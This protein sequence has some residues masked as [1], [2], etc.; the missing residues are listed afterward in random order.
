MTQDAGVVTETSVLPTADKGDYRPLVGSA[1]D[2]NGARIFLPWGLY[3]FV[4]EYNFT[5]NLRN[6]AEI[7]YDRWYMAPQMISRD[8]YWKSL[9]FPLTGVN[10]KLENYVTGKLENWTTGALQ[11]NGIDQYLTLKN[12]AADKNVDVVLKDTGK[13]PWGTGSA[14]KTAVF[15][16]AFD[17]TLTLNDDVPK[18]STLAVDVN[19][20]KG[21]NYGG[22]LGIVG[23]TKVTGPGPYKFSYKPQAVDGLTV[24]SITIYVS[25]TGGWGDATHRATRA[26]NKLDAPLSLNP[27]IGENN[28]LVETMLK[29][30]KDANGMIIEKKDKTGYSVVVNQAGNLAFTIANAAGS[31]VVTGKQIVNDD[32]WHHIIAEADRK[33]GR[34]TIYVDG[35][36]DVE[37]TG[38]KITG[39]IDS[40]T[41][42]FVAGTPDG[43]NL[44]ATLDFLRICRGNLAD[45]RTDIDELTAWQFAGSQFSDFTGAII[46]DGKRSAGAI[47]LK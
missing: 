21:P 32:K 7:I 18:G 2:G 17:F 35:K 20:F 33:S 47:S 12:I 26:V 13:E 24:Y 31:T 3:A 38:E 25:P 19:C 16:Q 15:G 27:N 8:D 22:W 40:A 44:A 6:P 1:T 41:D 5:P 10:V 11:L 43:I 9:T 37:E 39:N 30:A 36:I 4:G 46:P 42:L 34:M 28:F 23:R 45:A 14:P 29:I